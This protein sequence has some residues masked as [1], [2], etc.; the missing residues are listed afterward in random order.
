[1]KINYRVKANKN[2]GKWSKTQ[3]NNKQKYYCDMCGNKLWV[4]PDN[5]TIYCD[6]E[7]TTKEQAVG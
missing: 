5:K 1:M 4:A 6:K 7:H 2:I 3:H